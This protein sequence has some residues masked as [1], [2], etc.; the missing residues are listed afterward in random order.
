MATIHRSNHPIHIVSANRQYRA[1]TVRKYTHSYISGEIREKSSTY[2][3]Q[4]LGIKQTQVLRCYK[5]S[6]NV[7]EKLRRLEASLDLIVKDIWPRIFDEDDLR[8]INALSK[9]MYSDSVK[10][11]GMIK[12][13]SDSD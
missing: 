13:M 7:E 6:T 11:V 2:V 9:E 3:P 4:S 10:M 8:K 5:E 12:K 1:C